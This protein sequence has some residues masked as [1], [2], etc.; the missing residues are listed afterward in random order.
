MEL[1]KESAAKDYVCEKALEDKRLENA[2]K[3][4]RLKPNSASLDVVFGSDQ[5]DDDTTERHHFCSDMT[6]LSVASMQ[7]RIPV[8]A[9]N[10]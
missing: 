3:I 8:G 5:P 4:R 9:Q 6:R 1:V 7:S 10:Y 2:R